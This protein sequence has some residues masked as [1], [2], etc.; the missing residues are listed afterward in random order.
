V[1]IPDKRSQRWRSRGQRA[2]ATGEE[3]AAQPSAPRVHSLNASGDRTSEQAAL[4]RVH[5]GDNSTRWNMTLSRL[6][7][8]SVTGGPVFRLR[9]LSLPLLGVLGLITPVCFQGTCSRK[10]QASTRLR[11]RLT[12]PR[13][14]RLRPSS[15]WRCRLPRRHRSTVSGFTR[16][17]TVGCGCRTIGS[18]PTCRPTGNRPCTSTGRRSAGAGLPHLG[19]SAGDQNH[20]GVLA[21]AGIS[22]GTRGRGSS[23]VSTGQRSFVSCG[24]S[25]TATTGLS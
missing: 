8:F 7:A 15:A 13:T 9:G 18:T 23:G 21:G 20:I 10:T 1:R 4:G 24:P 12:I 25:T 6:K 16:V 3:V 11:H 19:C 2:L 22:P 17:N 5:D 14:R